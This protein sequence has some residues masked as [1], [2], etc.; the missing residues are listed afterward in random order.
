[1]PGLLLLNSFLTPLLHAL[2]PPTIPNRAQLLKKDPVRRANYPDSVREEE[3]APRLGGQTVI[4]TAIMLY[5]A[6]LGFWSAFV[7]EDRII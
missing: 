5:T 7:I 1:M 2:H 4:F 3:E 6:L